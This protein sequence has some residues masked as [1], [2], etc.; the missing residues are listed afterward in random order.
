MRSEAVA[1]TWLEGSKTL[2]LR[3]S[4]RLGTGELIWSGQRVL[5][6]AVRGVSPRVAVGST[7]FEG[8]YVRPGL[9]STFVL[10]RA[11]AR[12]LKRST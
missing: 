7:A 9:C 10:A 3:V 4:G 1:G 6:Y 12:C 11:Y 5:A 8:V 2:P